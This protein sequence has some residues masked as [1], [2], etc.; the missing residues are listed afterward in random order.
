MSNLFNEASLVLIPSG[1]KS[2][3]VYSQIPTNGNGDLTFTRASDAF[4][5]NANGLIQRVPYNLASRSEEFNNA[6]WTKTRSTIT[7]NTT[8]SPN[9]TTTAD[10]LVEDINFGSHDCQQTVAMTT[11]ISYTFSTYAKISENRYM[12]LRFFSGGAFTTN[13]IVQFDLLNGTATN[14]VTF[15]ASAFSITNVG[16]GWYRCTITQTTSSTANG[17]CGIQMS[18]D[19]I[20]SSYTGNGIDGIFLWGAQL[21]QGTTAETYFS[22]TDRLNVPRLSYMYGSCPALL[23]EPQ[24]TNLYLRTEDFA[25]SYWSKGNTS[26]TPNAQISPDGNNNGALLLA[27]GTTG[28]KSLTG[29]ISFTNGLTYTIS[30]YAKKNTNDFLQIT[31]AGVFLGLNAFANF[32]LN[33]GVLGTV[34]SGGTA[35]ITSVGNGWYR[36]TLT[37]TAI[38]TAIS[39]GG[40]YMVSSSTSVRAE[41]NSLDTSVYLWGAQL[42]QGA[43]PTTYIPTTTATVT[44]I[45]DAFTRN[46]IFTNGLITSSGGTWFVELRNNVAYLRDSIGA[47]WIGDNS[48][49]ASLGNA[50]GFRHGGSSQRLPVIKTVNGTLTT[51]YLTLT[52][53]VKIAIK[54]NG[55]TADVFVNGT[56][57]VSA[58]AFTTTNME[59]LCGQGSD[60]PKFIQ[61][62]ALY[63]TPLSDTDCI[64]LTT[65]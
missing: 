5:T 13:S 63:P 25:N 32:N 22:T 12:I 54:W 6:S 56:K 9:N 58:T 28:I 31:S 43:Y 65:L 49:A 18:K 53:N 30:V 48:T 50:L 33:N 42:E 27:N 24:R 2:G 35:T 40:F 26:I 59:F 7:A 4:R 64:A 10:K 16:N 44:R 39:S 52:D 45:A 17:N 38:S 15:P 29:N 8:T 46:N 1:Y 23:L 62:M 3:K 37:G 55:T 61:Q 19:G 11:G 34:G 57:V 20:T 47:I 41:S 60:V 14:S 21:V 51:L 36:C